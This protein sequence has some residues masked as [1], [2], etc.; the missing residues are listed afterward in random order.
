MAEPAQRAQLKA[1][2]R[3]LVRGPPG[4]AKGGFAGPDAGARGLLQLRGAGGAEP[5]GASEWSALRPE[6]YP[7]LEG[8]WRVPQIGGGGRDATV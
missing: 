3:P 2:D 5:R 4:A 1:F 6:P 8:T 7:R